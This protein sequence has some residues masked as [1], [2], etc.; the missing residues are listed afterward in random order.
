[1]QLGI[2]PEGYVYPREQHATRD[3]LRRFALVRP[4]VR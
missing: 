4:V 3:L 1:M 2:L